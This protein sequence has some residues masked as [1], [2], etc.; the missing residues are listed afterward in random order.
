MNEKTWVLHL[1]DRHNC[2]VLQ[3]LKPGEEREV[4]LVVHEAPTS[5]PVRVN[6]KRSADGKDFV[7]PTPDG[8]A[9]DISYADLLQRIAI[10]K[11][12]V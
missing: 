11:P 2:S 1:K 12:T 10:E 4:L 5:P 7:A 9:I 3:S 8:L 6:A